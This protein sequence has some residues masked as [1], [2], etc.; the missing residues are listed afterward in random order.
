MTTDTNEKSLAS[1]WN[2]PVSAA[3]PPAID[4][5]KPV[6]CIATTYTFDAAFFETDLLPR[7]LGL[8]FDNTERETSF[9]IEREQALGTTRACVLVDHTCVDAKQ[10]TLRWDQIP[11][12]VPGGAQHAKIVVLVWERW[13]RLIV[14]SA[15]LTKTGYRTNR[16]I[17][18]VL[19]FFDGEQSTPLQAAKDALNF[20]GEMAG[21][22]WVLGNDGS[23]A[24]LAEM[25]EFVRSRLNRWKEAPTAFTPRQLPRVSFVGGRPATGDRRMLSV[26]GQFGE[27]WGGR[28]ATDVAV[29]TPFV[30][31]TE[32]GMERLIEHLKDMSR[33]S[34]GSTNTYLAI[35][36]HPSQENGNARMI[37]NL[38][39]S[40]Q[41]VWNSK[42][43][44]IQEGPSIYIIPPARKHEKI[45]RTLH[46]KA[47]SLSDGE[48]DL[49]LCGSSNFTPHGMGEG[50]ANIEANLCYQDRAGSSVPLDARLPVLWYGDADD[51]CDDVFWPPETEPPPDEKPRQPPVPPVFKAV[52][53]NQKLGTLTIF[54]DSSHALP[55]AWSLVR[56][57]ARPS[58]GDSDLVDSIRVPTIPPDGQVSVEVPTTSRGL[59]LT[60]VRMAWTDENGQSLSAWIPVQTD[61]LD[62]LLPPEQFRALTSDHIMDCLISGREPAELVADDEDVTSPESPQPETPPTYDPLREIDTTGYTIYQ[63]R[64][65]GQTLAALAERLQKTV[66]TI[67][68]AKYR[69]H[70]DPLGPAALADALA[71]DLSADSHTAEGTQMR[72][73]Q[74]AFSLA[75]IAL[76][77]AYVC[78]RIHADRNPGDHDVRPVYRGVIEDLLGRAA[79]HNSS[80]GRAS[81]LRAYID[82]VNTKCAELVG[83][84]G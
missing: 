15:N 7:F 52:S 2:G 65:L 83:A 8:K 35:P 21:T 71:K 59:I 22:T 1:H 18:G 12:R 57:D 55:P 78:R 84:G 3:A 31:E 77:L 75:E 32:S 50:V 80:A 6:A 24:R 44:D 43:G 42:W 56:P 16:E 53:Y 47:L 67:Q 63:V 62:D 69:L 25:L 37:S 45:N 14:S 38:P 40:F 73:S 76:T 54:F 64:K 30:G 5:G 28:K 23:R 29:M 49:L 60:C 41:K 46:A 66:R 61:N 36:G 10:T 9:L 51:S 48:H 4:T 82:A 81:S 26:I 70:N 79:L 58:D 27:L 33:R 68:A 34:N 11:V 74:L 19:D 20:L 72:S 17:A 13:L 39:S